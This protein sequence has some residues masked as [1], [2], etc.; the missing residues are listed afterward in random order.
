VERFDV[1]IVGGGGTGSECAFR[2]GE[3]GRLKVGLVERDKL[4]G[5]CNNYGCVPTKALLKAAKIV[6]GAR[7]AE[8]YGIRIRGI[9]VDYPK[10]FERVRGIVWGMSKEGAAPFEK[11]GVRVFLGAEASFVGPHELSV[12]GERVGARKVIVACGTKPTA[13]PI[14]GLDEAGYWTNVQAVDPPRF[15][16]SLA[17]VGAG[18]IGVEFAQIYSRLG[19]RVTLL[20][21]LDRVLPPE[22]PESSA[23]IAQALEAEGI[24][25]LAGARIERV[26]AAGES[27]RVHLRGGRVIEAGELL[28][29]TGRVPAFDALNLPAAGVEVDEKGK[30]VLDDRLRTSIPHIWAAGDATGDLLFTH[31]GTYESQL[32]VDQ[33]AHR[34]RPRRD[35]RVVP[36]VTYCE[37]EVASVGLTEAAARQE[38]FDVRVGRAHFAGNERSV[39]EGETYGLVKVVADA[40]TGEVLGGHI[41]GEGAGEL[42]HEIV[43]L[44]AVR[45]RVRAAGDAIHSYPTL[46]ESV[47]GALLQAAVEPRR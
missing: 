38:G 18:P 5:E 9:E 45:G 6:H 11:V 35:Y 41:V 30:P 39:I 22:D 10:V 23:A 25:V 7:R 24:E 33:I 12:N 29:A 31:V 43:A 28:V 2:L 21:A 32:V 15:P 36:K 47:K 46:A 19:A 26:E 13:P 20:E 8:E 27:R 14:P 16:T 3:T 4:G 42:I 44:M 40:R 37:P 34:R 1:F 17:I